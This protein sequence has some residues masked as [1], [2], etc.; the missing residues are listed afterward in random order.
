MRDV[1]FVE[2]KAI[3]DFI[4]KGEAYVTQENIQGVL[5]TAEALK[6]TG[7]SYVPVQYLICHTPSPLPQSNELLSSGADPLYHP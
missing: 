1:K 4:Y 3:L 2:M 6:V 7:K 5:K